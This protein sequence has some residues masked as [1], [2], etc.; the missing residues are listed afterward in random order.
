MI[1]SDACRRICAQSLTTV[2]K[3]EAASSRPRR[4]RGFTLIEVLVVASI[5]ALLASI[6]LPA[7]RNARDQAKELTCAANLTGFNKGFYA[8][9]AANRDYL[10]SGAFDPG[11]KVNPTTP[12]SDDRDGPVDKVGW[13]ADQVN[14]KINFPAVQLC[15]TN[16]SKINQKLGKGSSAGAYTPA[17]ADALI[18]RGYNTNYTQAWFMARTQCKTATAKWKGVKDTQGPLKIARMLKVTPS[19]VP[20]MGDSSLESSDTLNGQVTIRTMTNGPISGPYDSQDYSDFGPQH[21]YGKVIVDGATKIR[22]E[23][24]RANVLMGDGH[25]EKFVDKVRDGRFK[26]T[27]TASGVVQDDLE[28]SR[29]F[30]GVLTLGRASRDAWELQ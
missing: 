29:V 23:R 18:R 22:T 26:Y 27:R 12:T 6:L 10:C 11:Q 16:P 5:I 25:V 21:G 7:M 8:Y 28:P 17:Q 4:Y 24:V 3:T 2:I 13:V 20:L 9:A 30:D 14:G 15:P 19:R 1:P